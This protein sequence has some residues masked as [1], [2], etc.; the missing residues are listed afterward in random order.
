VA[1]TSSSASHEAKKLSASIT[2]PP[3]RVRIPRKNTGPLVKGSFGVTA[4]DISPDQAGRYVAGGAD[5]QLH[6]GNLGI[7]GDTEEHEV[8]DDSGLSDI[9]RLAQRRIR[10]RQR[11]DDRKKKTALRG[12][13]GDIRS[14]RFFPSGEGET[15]DCLL[16][17]IF[18]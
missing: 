12:H 10:K 6:V 15:Q 17:L 8:D 7:G 16:S 1:S 2:V 13:V 11:E 18:D 5:G 14:A 3:T 9:D 4:F